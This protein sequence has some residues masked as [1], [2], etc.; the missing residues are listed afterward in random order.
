MERREFLALGLTVAG[1]A[2]ASGT[3][4]FTPGVATA[5][6]LAR[7]RGRPIPRSGEL[8]PEVGLGTWQTFDVGDSER[9]RAPL[10]AVLRRFFDL[11]GSVIDSSPMYGRAE[12]VAGDLT[13]ALG[14]RAFF[15][16][17]VWTSGREQGRAQIAQSM[18][19]LRLGDRPLDLLQVHN[20]LDLETHLPHLRELKESGRVRHL[21]F[22]HYALSRFPEMERL[23]KAEIFDFV[24]LPY[25]LRVRQAEDRLLPAARDTRTAV[26]VMRPFEEGSLF[27]LVKGREL[28]AWAREAGFSS[29]A[30]LFLAFILAHE[31]VT[32]VIPATSKA[33]HLE[34]NM[35]A[36][37]G[38]PLTPS[39]RAKL[40]SELG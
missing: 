30:E 17:K 25:S 24:Q 33:H 13:R 26:I 14:A 22:T 38:P 29:W 36:G 12:A 4:P 6:T 5:R 32:C 10:E 8:I 20:L 16:T 19:R 35:R 15:A 7:I 23:L 9:E 31:A 3:T 18:R 34:Q 28:P 37:L 27:Q 2:L 1:A 40:L 21:G 11:G 39:L